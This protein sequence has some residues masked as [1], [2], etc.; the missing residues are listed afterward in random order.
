MVLSGGFPGRRALPR[1]GI[2]TGGRMSGTMRSPTGARADL[3]ELT[4]ELSGEELLRR[5]EGRLERARKGLAA[6]L[7]TASP[8]TVEGLLEPLNRVLIGV[9]DAGVHSHL[10]FS[11]HTEEATRSAARDASEAVDR[12]FH[13]LRLD[14]RL[15]AALRAIDLSSEDADT[16][17]AVEKLL[18]DMRRAG[19]EKDDATRAR[20][21][22]LNR[23]IDRVANRFSE[24]I[25]TRDRSVEVASPDELEG[26]PS[27]FVAAHPPDARGKVTL[28]TKYPDFLPVMAYADRSELRQRLLLEFTNRA[29]PENQPVLEELLRL[30]YELARTL[31][32]PSFAAFATEDKMIEN[33]EAALRLF[34]RIEELL[35]DPARADL[36]RFLTRKRVDDPDAT[37]VF[38]WEAQFFGAGYYDQKI[39]TEEFGVDMREL[40]SYLPYGRVRDGL[41]ELCRELFGITFER[42]AAPAWHPTVEVYDVARRGQPLGRIYLDLAPRDGKYNHAACFTVRDGLRGERLPQSALVC[43]FLTPGAPP[44]T[45][46]L[47]Y[48][49]VVTFFH[50]FGHLLH[51]V[52]SGHQRWFLNGMSNL[53]WD[54]I[55][56]PSQ[57][58]EEWARDPATLARFA[59]DP[60][61][62]AAAPSELLQRLKASA[63]LGRSAAWLRQVGFAS[64]SLDLH[65]GDPVGQ[66][67]SKLA[68]A[69]HNRYAP[70][71]M[72]PEYHFEASFGHLTGYSA[73]Y[74]TYVWSLVIARDLLAPF[75]EQGSLTSPELAERYAR[76]ILV[77]GSTR[78][79]R[80]LIRNYLGR[81]FDYAAFTRWAT[82]PA[83][84]PPSA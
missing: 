52:L 79:A 73:I 54:F 14:R 66:D 70:T 27:D 28:T 72:L 44:E 74:Y 39:R 78:P 10:V 68:H 84:A 47:E 46:R 34:K 62:G 3:D 60:D 80:E 4:F 42:S 37:R 83:I 21:L 58:F 9:G 29:H 69:A 31:G 81:E 1:G 22:E 67:L 61:T 7:E 6:L 82:E 8:P 20:L 75:L 38:P 36:D 63:P 23:A 56:A 49:Q 71:P 53:E 45:D 41:F 2:M 48:T 24:N 77:P 50:E 55:E 57:L 16:R 26:L 40:R 19:V 33:P 43:N 17:F 64:V 51:A 15:Y 13:E 30:R 12:F 59:V 11:V 35:H 18:R 76:E 25:A 65:L 5:V 32:Y